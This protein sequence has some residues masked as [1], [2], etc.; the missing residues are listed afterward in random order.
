[1]RDM[2]SRLLHLS[3]I[4]AS[5]TATGLAE[6]WKSPLPPE[7]VP[8]GLFNLPDDF[9]ITIWAQ[10]P[11]LYNPTNF[12]TDDQGNIFV[13]EGV[14]YRKHNGRRPEGDRIT[15]LRDTDGNGT[16][17]SSHTFVQEEGLVAPLG[18]SVFD[19]QIVVAQ[20]PDIIV[21]TDVDRDLKFDPEVDKREVLMSGFNSFNHDH[22]LHAVSAGPDGKWYIN[23]GNCGAIFTDNDGKTFY[24]RSPY[25]GGSEGDVP[26][27]EIADKRSDDGYYYN[28]GFL[29][30][31]N[32]D[33]TGTEIVGQ[34]FRNSYEHV[35]T[36]FGDVFQND[37]DDPPACRVSFLMEYGNTGYYSLDGRRFWNTDRRPGEKTESAH[38]RQLDPGTCDVGDVYGSGSPTGMTFYENGAMGEDFIGTLLNCEPGSNTIYSY[39]P[40]RKGGTYALDRNVFVRSQNDDKYRADGRKH[41]FDVQGE[42][43]QRIQFRPSDV[44][45]G[46]DGALY[47]ADWYDRRVGGHGDIDDSCSGTIYRIAPKGFKPQIPAIDRNTIPGLITALRS[48]AKHV[49]YTGFIGLRAR[50]AEAYPAIARLLKDENPYIAARGI[51][52]LPYLGE[53]GRSHCNDLLEH[54]DE[55]FRLT[56]FRAL[57]A[58][59]GS[60]NDAAA[61]LAR[62]PSV[63][64]RRDVALALRGEAAD[65]AHPLLMELYEQWDGSDKNML[66]AIG[67]AVE[68]HEAEFW[69]DASTSLKLGE[70]ETWSD[71][72][73]RLAWR[74]MTPNTVPGLLARAKSASL[75]SEQRHF[76][77]EAIAF[78]T[79]QSA[80]DAMVELHGIPELQEMAKFWLVSRAFGTWE[81]FGAPAAIESL[82]YYDPNAIAV[83]AIVPK[84]DPAK[85]LKAADVLAL[86]G[87]ATRG[88]QVANRCLMCHQFDDTGIAYGPELKGWGR[89]QSRDVIVGA[90]IDPSA[91]IAHGYDG[92]VT[93][94]KDGKTIHGLVL[95]RNSHYLKLLS[96]GGLTQTIAQENVKDRKKFDRSL[97]LSADQLGLTPQDVADLVEFLKSY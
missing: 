88:R 97:M 64:I 32:P 42:E 10:S 46:A 20:P 39:K 15:V 69:D 8:V 91:E 27:H 36:S 94:T 30:R 93:R 47:I 90:I 21:Y 48:P 67:R 22:S 74:M 18:V 5:L 37:N 80:A 92:Q 38:W 70:G 16:A 49:R 68:N 59:D 84:P 96:T 61:K 23:N 1:M 12:D 55:A 2:R 25:I 86:T 28:A 60:A 62:D 26:S 40:E 82:G 31:I 65:L 73:T 81:D 11:M 76:A 63:S 6:E 75:T 87:D 52:L 13:A 9:E 29:A 79:S 66:E 41:R 71:K 83:D 24:M 53:K 7:S 4:L 89:N 3:S 44:M 58:A 54:S 78:V 50:G 85:Q 19:N 43:L 56:A 17:D 72:E 77:M 33:G 45:V 51:W 57:R 35:N 34:G 14:N 95:E